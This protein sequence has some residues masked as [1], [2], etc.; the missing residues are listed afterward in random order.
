MESERIQSFEAFWPYYVGEH[1]VPV[2]RGLHYVGTTGALVLLGVALTVGPW[3][4]VLLM[5]F[6][7]YGGAWFGHFVVERNRP[8]TF[9]YPLWSLRGD[10]RM[11]RFALMGRMRAE[12]VRLYGS[13]HPAPDAPLLAD[14]GL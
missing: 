11:L 7:G 13:A 10:F 14:S 5:G 12:V 2:N 6:A 4:L 9:T 8:A 1:R 3:W